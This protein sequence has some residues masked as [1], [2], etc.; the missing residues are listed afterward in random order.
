MTTERAEI[1]LRALRDNGGTG[2][3]YQISQLTGIPKGQ[4]NSFLYGPEARGLLHRSAETVVWSLHLSLPAAD[5]KE[6]I[7]AEMRRAAAPVKASHLAARLGYPK[8]TINRELYKM[9]SE[10]CVF[11]PQ[12][13]QWQLPA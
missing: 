8:S 3:A 6:K 7:L 2:T 13:P 10:G 1:I 4:V 9:K 5:L 11:N 12:H